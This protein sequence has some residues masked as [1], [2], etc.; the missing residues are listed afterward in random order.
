MNNKKRVLF[1]AT[2]VKSHINVFHLPYLK[3][4]KDNGYETHVC[5]R[6]DF[7]GEECI[8]PNC[9][10]HYDIP[11]ER[12][13]INLNNFKA[14]KQLKKIINENE[15]EIIHCNTPVAS[16]LTRLAA[17]KVR[18]KGTKV[19]YTA[20]GFH[21]FKGAPLLN[22][23]LYYPAEKI[24]SYFT[25]VLIT[26]NKEDYEIAK[27]KMKA[28]KIEYVPGVGVDIEKFKNTKVDK[29]KK[30]KEL[31][32]NKNDIVLLSVGELSKRKNHKVI[33]EA[34]SKFEDTRIKYII[35]GRGSLENELKKMINN[36]N[37]Q[38]RV[39][40]LGFRTD[41]VDLCSISDIFC[42]P[43]K[44][45]G[46]PVALMEAMS[47]GLPCIVSDIRGNCDLIHNEKGGYLC[48]AD[49]IENLCKYIDILIQNED[50]RDSMG[51]YNL[52][53]IKNFDIKIIKNKVE[54]VYK[55]L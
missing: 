12:S 48:L 51:I 3:W 28:K 21:F 46:L 43:S 6:D 7:D 32:L 49:D 20:H 27:R 29:E 42:F 26:I 38:N 13:P 44:Q 19:I 2:V 1:V 25:D 39:Y 5:A 9:D 23:L 16:I 33:I 30:R 41:I 55:I 52:E 45:E 11:F 47:S 37:L 10:V 14:Y 31:G 50:L 22:W 17:I 8:I 35:V 15:Y 4:F 53:K 24:C 34:L 54:Q 40:L 36:L 18:K